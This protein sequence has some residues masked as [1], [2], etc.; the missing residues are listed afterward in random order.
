MR[1]LAVFLSFFLMA[2]A[3]AAADISVDT[4]QDVKTS[5]D[6]S[7]SGRT[8]AE[9]RDSKTKRKSYSKSV[10][11]DK[12][13][14]HSGKFAATMD[15]QNSLDLQL[16]IATLFL[17]DSQKWMTQADFGLG[18]NQGN[19]WVSATVQDSQAKLAKANAKITD[20]DVSEAAIRGYILALAK[21]G[22]VIAQAVIYLQEDVAAIGT[23]IRRPGDVVE[24]RG[25]G[26]ADLTILAAGAIEKALKGLSDSRLALAME[27]IKKDVNGSVCR[28]NGEVG[29]V[30]CGSVTLQIS[31]PPV[32]RFNGIPW[33]GAQ[34]GFGGM[35]GTYRIASNWSYSQALE[36]MK[37]DAHYSKWAAEVSAAAENMEAQGKSREAVVT[38]RKA[39]EKAASSK[40]GLS[41]A[42]FLPNHQQ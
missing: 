28:F 5:K 4:G 36:S 32:I 7:V 22:S 18:G 23:L 6:K 38:K 8:S 29:L 3:G 30:K 12:S 15:R 9:S 42:R 25:L 13:I 37:S 14:S 27:Q 35:T 39:V 11:G 26:S 17:I 2:R 34:E 41:V 40:V 24:V 1:K 20:A 19:S 21:Q 33:F 31:V 16:P 10:G